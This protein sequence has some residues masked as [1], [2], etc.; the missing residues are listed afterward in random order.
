MKGLLTRSYEENTDPLLHV[1]K[2]NVTPKQELTCPSDLLMGQ[3]LRSSLTFATSSLNPNYSVKRFKL[4]NFDRINKNNI[5]VRA[6][7]NS[8]DLKISNQPYATRI[9]VLEPGSIILNSGRNDSVID[10]NDTI[11]RKNRKF[12]KPFPYTQIIH[13]HQEH[14][15]NNAD[16]YVENDYLFSNSFPTDRSVP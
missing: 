16:N 6:P 3:R 9:L 5:I 15:K 1:L 7:E 4:G 2:Y 8:N 13:D 14:P 12:L 11:Y 10:V